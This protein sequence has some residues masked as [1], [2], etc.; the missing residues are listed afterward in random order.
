MPEANAG[1]QKKKAED[2]KEHGRKHFCLRP[3]Y[4]GLKDVNIGDG[5]NLY[6]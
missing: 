2:G 6:P 4:C 5:H 3:I 1:N